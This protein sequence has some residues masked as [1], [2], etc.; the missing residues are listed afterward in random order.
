[1]PGGTGPA[2]PATDEVQKLVDS[3]KDDAQTKCQAAGRNGIF[4][5]FEAKNFKTQVVAGT[6]YFVEVMV[7]DTEAVHLR[8]YE[9]LPHTGEPASVASVK[10]GMAPGAEIDFF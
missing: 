10:V 9:P 5:K 1:M 6:N 2:Q 3:V 7:S 4:G 8:V